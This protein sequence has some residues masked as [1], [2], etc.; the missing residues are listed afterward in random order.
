MNPI[1]AIAGKNFAT[2]FAL[3]IYVLVVAG[4]WAYCSIQTTA[5]REVPPNVLKIGLFLLSAHAGVN[6]TDKFKKP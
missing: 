5:M 4:V 6:V 2:G 3:I 1:Q